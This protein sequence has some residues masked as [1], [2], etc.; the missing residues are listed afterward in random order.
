[1]EEVTSD[2]Q[3]QE[4]TKKKRF[5]IFSAL[6]LLP[7]EARK[8]IF[9]DLRNAQAAAAS[10]V[11]DKRATGG[12][13]YNYAS[14]DQ[15]KGIAK[16]AL[17]VNRLSLVCV[18]NEYD[19]EETFRKSDATFDVYFNFVLMHDS[20]HYLP[21]DFQITACPRN[22]MP[23]DKAM[24]AA[25]TEAEGFV[26]MGWLL[27]EREDEQSIS[28]RDD[29]GYTPGRP[30]NN[31]GS[32]PGAAPG[33]QPGSY[34]GG[35][36]ERSSGP[37]SQA[38]A[39]TGKS[40]GNSALEPGAQAEK[41]KPAQAAQAGSQGSSGGAASAGPGAQPKSSQAGSQAAAIQ[42]PDA[43]QL[44]T[45]QALSAEIDKLDKES[46]TYAAISE[47]VKKADAK[48]KELAAALQKEGKHKKCGVLSLIMNGHEDKIRAALPAP[49]K[50]EDVDF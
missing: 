35:N 12:A 37:G 8:E 39:A 24:L 33:S 18:G 2:N 45:F 23:A 16:E 32:K 28:A 29:S 40:G 21:F 25:K 48:C 27:I 15:L 7:I 19:R 4:I 6:S 5:D 14:M 31:G 42:E 11:K 1:M 13:G 34:G 30:N 20:G 50:A 43:K 47:L 10:A 26:C 17:N 44:A 22:G 46:A 3:A 38:K 9:P 49:A 36:Q 41:E